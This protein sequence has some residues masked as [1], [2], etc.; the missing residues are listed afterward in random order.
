MLVIDFAFL[1]PLLLY[2]FL[3]NLDSINYLHKSEAHD[4]TTPHNLSWSHA[5]SYIKY[6]KYYYT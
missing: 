4:P 6:V 1:I 5:L 2:N 3:A